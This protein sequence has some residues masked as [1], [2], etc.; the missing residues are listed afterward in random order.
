MH[1]ASSTNPDT[2][3]DFLSAQNAYQEGKFDGVGFVF[4]GSDGLV[5]V[6]LDDCYAEGQF[7]APEAAQI[8]ESIPGYMEV[9]PSG[10]GVKIFTLADIQSAHVDHEKGL[11]VYPRGRYFTVTGRVLRTGIPASP[12]DLSPFIPERTLRVTGDAFADYTP[13]VAEYDVSRVE[14][15][16]LD[17]LDP[18][19]GYTEWLKVGMALHHQFNGDVEACEA[20]DRW[21]EKATRSGAYHP[22]ECAKKLNSIYI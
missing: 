21:S 12:I 5:G 18:D 6:D 22:G 4:D 20:W 8:A 3:T 13:P 7:T 10:T 11:E 14:S 17:H 1:A 9:S 16:L 19:C 2:W 15:E